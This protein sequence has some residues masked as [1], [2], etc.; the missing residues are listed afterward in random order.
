MPILIPGTPKKSDSYYRRRKKHALFCRGAA[1][2]PTI[3][4]VKADHRMGSNYLKR[5]MGDAVK[6]DALS[7]I[8]LQESDERS[9]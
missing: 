8:Q 6:P 2:E 9:A 5:I 4:H 7:S 1:I 3:G